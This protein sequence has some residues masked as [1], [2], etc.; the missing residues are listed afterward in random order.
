MNNLKAVFMGTPD[1][2]VPCLKRLNEIS[3]VIAVVTQPDKKRGRGQKLTPSPIKAFALDNQLPVFQPAKVKSPDFVE[4]LSRLNPDI[5]IVVA[6]G[7]ILSQDI[8]NIPPKGC[9]N[10]HASLL[11]AYRGAAPI[12]WS[13]IR[14]E[15]LTGVTTMYM[16]AG[17]DT[18]DMILKTAVSITDDMTTEELH[19]KLMAAGADLLAETIEQ[20]QKGTV[21][22]EKQNN[23]LSSYSPMLN[24]D[25]CRIDWNKSA[26][27]IHNLVRGLNSW[28]GA[29]SIIDGQKMKI[30]RTSVVDSLA[31]S[32]PGK[33]TALTKNGLLVAAGE[34][35]V[36]ILELQTPNKKKMSA[37]AYIN[38]HKLQLPL[39]FE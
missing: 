3:E 19:D 10:V 36:E 15:T 37:K 31:D 33:V 14:G 2:A 11:P 16:D 39:Q 7:Q 25:I 28:P 18:G 21:L 4:Q 24:D 20:I 12:H 34:N 30:W 5:I 32:T 29:Y 22:H 23:E 13:I 17:L 35:S 6:F 38:G 8:L 9:I 26:R 1:F 27:D